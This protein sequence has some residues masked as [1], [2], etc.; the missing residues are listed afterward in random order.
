MENV[1]ETLLTSEIDK[2][3]AR[4]KKPV[5]KIEAIK[6]IIISKISVLVHE[7]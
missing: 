3:T 7:K 4:I 1:I 6:I 5:N 2:N